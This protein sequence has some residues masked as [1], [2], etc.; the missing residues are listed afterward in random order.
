MALSFSVMMFGCGTNAETE[1][2]ANSTT[3]V[4][5]TTTPTEAPTST[6]TEAPTPTPTEEPTPT[7]TEAPVVEETVSFEEDIAGKYWAENFYNGYNG[8]YFDGDKVIIGQKGKGQTEY[9]YYLEEDNWVNIDGDSYMY[10]LVD[11]ELSLGM[12]PL[13]TYTYTEVDK[14][15]F[16]S[17]FFATSFENDVVGK[18]WVEAEYGGIN[19]Y[20]FDE[21]K[22]IKAE[23]DNGRTEYSYYLEEDSWVNIGGA[24]YHYTL[25]DGQ[26]SLATPPEEGYIYE[27][28]DKAEFDNIFKSST[29]GDNSEGQ[30]NSLYDIEGTYW[31]CEWTDGDEYG[32]KGINFRD[33]MAYASST[34]N[35]SFEIGVMEAYSFEDSFIE[36]EGWGCCEIVNGKLFFEQ[37][38]H[39]YYEQVDV[40]TFNNAIF[41]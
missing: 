39:Q 21:D 38:E 8:Y 11:G 31:L 16:D 2:D 36:I 7:P 37:H 13:E 3:K 32:A 5:G 24:S 29:E 1:K 33:G 30:N 34:A 19:G 20:Y 40:D 15:E 12:P 14:A 41:K 17:L 9:S 23:K 18:Y 35:G 10:E 28:V 6:P 4:E 27:K 26:L 22:V 25:W